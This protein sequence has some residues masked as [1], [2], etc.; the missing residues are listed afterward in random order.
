MRY[1]ARKIV[2]I[3]NAV[4]SFRSGVSTLILKKKIDISCEKSQICCNDAKAINS[5]SG[6]AAGVNL[7]KKQQADTLVYNLGQC[8]TP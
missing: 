5:A 1:A 8:I 7:T 3:N 6:S 4:G 2:S